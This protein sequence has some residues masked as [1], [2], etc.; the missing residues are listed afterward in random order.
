MN[1][2]AGGFAGGYGAPP[3]PASVPAWQ[4]HHTPDGRAYY[5]NA[6]TK[7]TQWTK[8]EEIMTPAERALATQPWKEYTAEGGRKYW[9]NTDAKQSSWEMPEAFKNAL[10]ANDTRNYAAPPASYGQGGQGSHGQ[11]YGGAHRQGY[12]DQ[13]RGGRDSRD[14][15][16]L[17]RSFVPA[18]IDN[19]PEY[20]TKEEAVAAFIKVVKRYGVQPDWTWEQVLKTVGKDQQ[21]RSIKNPKA[22]KE[23]FAKYCQNVVLEEQERAKERLAKLRADFETMLKRHPDIT[24]STRWKTARPIIEGETIFRSTDDDKEREQL[25][26][27][28]I[29][30]LKKA[31]HEQQKT[32]RKAALSGLKELLPKLDLTAYTRWDDAQQ[33]VSVAQKDPKYQVL[34]MSEIITEFQ[35]HSKYLERAVNEKRQTDK[36]T[37]FRRQRRHRDAYRALLAD[38]LRDGKIKAGSQW[39]QVRQV[40]KDDERY[41]NMLAQGGVS[42]APLLFWDVVEDEER[43]L[44]GPRN[45]V[46][47]ALEVSF[48]GFPRGLTEVNI[49]TKDKRFDLTATTTV[50]EFMA[51]MKE[52]RRTANTDPGTL[53]LIFERVSLSSPHCVEI[54]SNIPLKL[55]EKRA[56]KRED[57]RHTDRHQR[58]AVDNLRSFMKRLDPPIMPGDTYENVRSR[59]SKAPEFQAVGS[60]DSAR[61]AFDR[62]MR[63]LRERVDEEPQLER[64]HHRRNS[65][66]SSERDLPRRA[67]DRS[68]GERSHRGGRSSRRSRSPGQD[69]YEA[70]RRRAVAERERNHRKSAMAENVLSGDR[71]R[72]SPPPR[73]ERDR[74]HR[75]R[76]RDHDR[77]ARPRRSED[78]PYTRE[79]RDRED[80]RERPRRPID[81]RS[82]DELNYGDDRPAG[83]SSSRRRRPDDDNALDRRDSR[84]SKRL[85]T[86]R[87]GE[88]TPQRE[89]RQQRTKTPPPAAPEEARDVRSGSEEGEIEE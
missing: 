4:E 54:S 82:A 10:G 49:I 16:Q 89:G 33:I 20:A 56:V 75:E 17:A 8:P 65:L 7:V 14:D 57:E 18:A 46:L 2:F 23:E 69:P 39:S 22:R 26:D 71:G 76:D 67:R 64:N 84:D 31:H 70:D 28:Y 74:D 80:E 19:G 50:D 36:K 51:V 29:L 60:E 79:R 24:H 62:H 78:M 48:S 86:D 63:R 42:T 34:T 58:H 11:G 68:R 43:A 13:G 47:D 73:R 83:P 27:E 21:F 6:T 12:R 15:R 72:L 9:Y 59:L 77:Y 55:R 81:T 32:Q 44:R 38:L 87:S 66:V 40:V 35:E 61:H 45:D 1:G 25:F 30:G 53:H 52:D 37:K 85:K 88:R 41:R 5:Y 3:A